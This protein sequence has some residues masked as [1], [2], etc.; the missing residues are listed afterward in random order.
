MKLQ[1]VKGFT[2]IE[3]M[4]VMAIVGILAA[5][6]YP[7]YQEHVQKTRRGD[8]AGE[9]ALLANAME[10]HFTLNGVYNNPVPTLGNAAGDIFPATCPID[11]AGPAVAGGRVYYNFTIVAGQLGATTYT[12]QAAPTGIQTGDKCGN[13]TLTQAG[14]KGNSAGLPLT[15]CW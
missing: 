11:E 6:A 12:I 1:A 5:I 3:L 13:L 4:I 15:E 2:L 8:C 7:S 10:R 14:V 9:L